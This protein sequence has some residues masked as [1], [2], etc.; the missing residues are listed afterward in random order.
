MKNK[1]KNKIIIG[2]LISIFAGF[3][4]A[5]ASAINYDYVTEAI[6][7]DSSISY[8]EN[9]QALLVID[10]NAL[11]SE[12]VK[13]QD[14]DEYMAKL[15]DYYELATVNINDTIYEGE[16]YIVASNGSVQKKQAS[17]TYGRS[18][19]NIAVY[20]ESVSVLILNI[21]DSYDL[22]MDRHNYTWAGTLA[23]RPVTPED[24][25]HFMG[26][27]NT[28]G[29]YAK[30]INFET[31]ICSELDVEFWMVDKENRMID[32]PGSIHHNTYVVMK[33]ELRDPDG[34]ISP[35]KTNEVFDNYGI[36]NLYLNVLENGLLRVDIE[37]ESD[38]TL[39]GR[40]GE[41]DGL[42]IPIGYDFRITV[43]DCGEEMGQFGNLYYAYDYA[44][45]D[46]EGFISSD[47]YDYIFAELTF[48]PR[49]G[50]IR[51]ENLDPNNTKV[52][53]NGVFQILQP[54]TAQNDYWNNE[55]GH[56]ISIPLPEYKQPMS[57]F[58]Y[59]VYDINTDEEV[60]ADILHKTDAEGRFTLKTN[61]YAIFKV[62]EY[63]DD[64]DEYEFWAWATDIFDSIE[65]QPDIVTENRDY[66]VASVDD[67]NYDDIYNGDGTK[68][69]K[70]F[71]PVKRGEKMTYVVS[72]KQNTENESEDIVVPNTGKHTRN[73][74]AYAAVT[75]GNVVCLCAIATTILGSFTI[76]KRKISR[77]KRLDA[78][79]LL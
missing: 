20:P 44:E 26:T 14:H 68:F 58:S 62:Y 12:Y 73:N 79:K 8:D 2:A 52:V 25:D 21:D 40:Y 67:V 34:N 11:E 31:Y 16:Y 74:D 35:M 24:E 42:T 47:E 60:E 7:A 3:W 27:I 17:R 6:K 29:I 76:I 43:F 13:Y 1:I 10:F 61:Q 18:T 72:S 48:L 32:N 50:E 75:I 51:I 78:F 70:N 5:N 36:D 23:G 39:S 9:N 22:W 65:I 41:I 57:N 63:P 53:D 38:P 45:S 54:V 49:T 19:G 37:D 28:A 4:A 55:A 46:E 56:Y 30:T 66:Y 33:L 59:K 69:T 71:A 64:M 15:A 77:R